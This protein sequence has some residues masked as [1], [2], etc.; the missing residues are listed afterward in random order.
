MGWANQIRILNLQFDSL[1]AT[2]GQGL[3]NLF[4]PI[5]QVINTLLGKLSVLAEA[6]KSFTE[7]ITGNQSSSGSGIGALAAEAD[8]GLSGAADSASDLADQTEGVGT[9][10][11]KAV[12][13]MRSLMG[14]DVVNKLNDTSESN[15]G[16]SDS[17]SD[18]GGGTPGLVPDIDFG[19]LASGETVI[20]KTDSKL[21]GLI[22]RC[23]ELKELFLAGFE[24]GFGNSDEKIESIKQHLQSIGQA[25][26]DIFTAPEVI[27]AANGL[28]DSFAVNAG[29]IAG[30]MVSIGL[31]IADN[32]VGGIDSY[33]TESQ[34]YI[35]ERIVSIL[36][37]SSEIAGL[38][39]DF[40]VAFADVF[41]VFSGESAKGI[42]ASLIG[43]VSDTF[44]SIL[45]L[46]LF[47]IRDIIDL[48]VAPFEE[49]VDGLKLALE[50][51]L[52]PIDSVLDTIHTGVQ[53][54]FQGILDMYEQHIS[55]MF[56]SIK[57]GLS[58][59]VGKLLDSF[60]TYIAPVL[61]NLASRFDETWKKH[62][63]PMIDGFIDLF[64]DIADIVTE[65]WEGTLEPFLTF[66]ASVLGPVISGVIDAVDEYFWFL[67]DTIID[68]VKAI[69]KLF[70]GFIDFFA[71]TL[72]G[73]WKRALK[74]IV[75]AF[76]SIFGGIADIGRNVINLLIDIIN[77]VIRGLNKIKLPDWVPSIGGKGINLPEIPHLAQGGFVEKNTPQLAMIGD[78]RHQG[79]IV[80]PEGKLLEM[81]KMAAS[82]GG[83]PE[84]LQKIISLLETLI[85]LVQ[86]GDDIVLAIDSEELARAVMTGS[87][88]LKRRYTTVEVTI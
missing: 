68:V 49:N 29:K 18:S 22:D 13:E 65:V 60:N 20:D 23:K 31:T 14:F 59:I 40:A 38:S 16:D 45:N 71:G 69:I 30:S 78:N 50:N 34:D 79:E 80:A 43:I 47:F 84:L 63:Q 39:G 77:S 21:Q 73:N 15:D 19:G 55:P 57:E 26:E 56:E 81:A 1:K 28:L 51:I 70:E 82:M 35:K 85:S 17:G 88:R 7:L 46:G 52:S 67:F 86:G 37:V 25:L 87:L 5:L 9:A 62:I 58:E 54:T 10:A 12:K 27:S 36:N 83:S 32:L 8:T 11:K 74:G 6:F 41:N 4:T 2:I 66:M 33:L 75:K 44:L 53:D 3:I 72:T 48:V 76:D 42:T 61:D 64:G 24:I